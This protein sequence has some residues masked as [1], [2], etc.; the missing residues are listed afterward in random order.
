[1]ATFINSAVQW[2]Y[3]TAPGNILLVM[4]IFLVV[5]HV[6]KVIREHDE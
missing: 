1:M 2:L 3:H 5:Y 4:L 6:T